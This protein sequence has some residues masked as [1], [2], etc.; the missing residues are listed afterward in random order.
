MDKEEAAIILQEML[1]DIKQI[2]NE[3][4]PKLSGKQDNLIKDAKF[5][6]DKAQRSLF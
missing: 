6:I 3:V 1:N 2:R 4:I 5:A